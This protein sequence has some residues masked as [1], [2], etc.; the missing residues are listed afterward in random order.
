MRDFFILHPS[1]FI[2]SFLVLAEPCGIRVGHVGQGIGGGVAGCNSRHYL[3]ASPVD[4]AGCDAF[5]AVFRHSHGPGRGER[6]VPDSR[7]GTNVSY[8]RLCRPILGAGG[9]IW[10]YLYKALWPLNLVFVYPQWHTKA[11]NPLWWLPLAAALAVT[12]VLWRYRKG[13]ARPLLFAWG[14][15]CV[16]LRRS[17]D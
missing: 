8:R 11:G 12:A 15:F 6:L 1:S 4:K 10:F 16:A 9:V 17:W 3:V 7:H 13:W 14:F 5:R 2:L